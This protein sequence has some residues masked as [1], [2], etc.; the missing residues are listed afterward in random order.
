MNRNSGR[1]ELD[2]QRFC[3]NRRNAQ[4]KVRVLR[5]N[6]NQNVELITSKRVYVTGGVAKEFV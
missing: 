4:K 1:G 3:C 5:Y 2:D 6:K